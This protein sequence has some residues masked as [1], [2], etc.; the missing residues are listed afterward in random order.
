[1]SKLSAVTAVLQI[2]SSERAFTCS[3]KVEDYNEATGNI[4]LRLAEEGWFNGEDVYSVEKEW[5]ERTKDKEECIADLSQLEWT[6]HGFARGYL[7]S[8]NFERQT[9]AV[10]CF[11]TRF[12]E[13]RVAIC[14][15]LNQLIGTYQAWGLDG[16]VSGDPD[17]W[18]DHPQ[19]VASCATASGLSHPPVVRERSLVLK[20][21]EWELIPFDFTLVD[22]DDPY[23]LHDG[24]D[25]LRKHVADVIAG[26]AENCVKNTLKTFPDVPENL[27]K[28]KEAAAWALVEDEVRRQLV[29]WMPRKS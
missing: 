23:L 26:V 10:S 2:F 3:F 27:A 12:A 6:L 11:G 8:K 15:T 16:L 25:D 18:T 24:A 4:I 19:V 1:M 5:V 17:G 28:S 29:S 14:S 9:F 20:E 21:V 22:P 7:R 13:A